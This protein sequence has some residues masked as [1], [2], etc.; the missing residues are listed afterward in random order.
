MKDKL[1]CD[2]CSKYRANVNVLRGRIQNGS[3]KSQFTNDRYLSKDELLQ[4]LKNLEL[5]KKKSY[6]KISRLA[7]AIRNNII[8]HG[9]CADE[10]T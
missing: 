2:I 8:E 1:R 5:E 7:H 4:K 3:N 10:E 9:I 6:Q